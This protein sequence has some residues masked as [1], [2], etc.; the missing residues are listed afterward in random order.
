MRPATKLICERVAA[1]YGLTVEDIVGRSRLKSYAEARQVAM[2]IARKSL[3]LSYPE[4][5][6]EFSRDHTSVMHAVARADDATGTMAQARQRLYA[7]MVRG[8][9]YTVGLW[10]DATGAREI[11]FWSN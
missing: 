9:A 4:L 3:A 6:R 7:E 11:E 2:W 8:T 5:G 1:H 10:S